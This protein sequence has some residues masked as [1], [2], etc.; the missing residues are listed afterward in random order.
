M[1]KF[2]LAN[3]SFELAGAALKHSYVN[4]RIVVNSQLWAL[5]SLPG[6]DKESSSGFKALQ[7][8]INSCLPAI[9]I[10]EVYTEDWHPIIVFMC[11]QRLPRY[12]ITLWEQSVGDNSSLSLWKDMDVYI[13][14][15]LNSRLSARS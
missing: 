5:F 3:A 15:D 9:Y 14:T 2:P 7:R 6:L 4:P 12:T 1:S 13:R 8:G 11:T 10:H